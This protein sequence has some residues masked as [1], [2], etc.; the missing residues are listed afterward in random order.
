MGERLLRAPLRI[1]QRRA[2]IVVGFHHV[3]PDLERLLQVGQGLV[4][5]A[6]DH[7]QGGRGRRGPRRRRD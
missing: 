1:V 7:Q 4:V 6:F 2:Q 3:G 5:V